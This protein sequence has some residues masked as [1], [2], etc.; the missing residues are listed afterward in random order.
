MQNNNSKT[1]TVL[2]AILIILALGIIWFQWDEMKRDEI[3][4]EE[5]NSIGIKEQEI[6]KFENKFFDFIDTY[7]IEQDMG[8]PRILFMKPEYDQIIF[9]YPTSQ[10]TS[11]YGVYNYKSNLL[12]KGIGGNDYVIRTTPVIFVGQDKLLVYSVNYDLPEKDGIEKGE[13]SIRDFKNN[14]IKVLLSSTTFSEAYQATDKS[15][16]IDTNR[17]DSGRFNLNTETLELSPWKR[18]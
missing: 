14:V 1:N 11:E 13:L 16:T 10:E 4:R 2:L 3:K 7:T 18:N 6:V 9:E 12:Y 8:T 5:S 17:Q 15:I